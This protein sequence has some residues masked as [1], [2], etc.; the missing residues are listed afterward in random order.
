V[1]GAFASTETWALPPTA[2]DSGESWSVSVILSYSETVSAREMVTETVTAFVTRGDSY[3]IV[4]ESASLVR[5]VTFETAGATRLTAIVYQPIVIPV[6]RTT[7]VR[8]QLSLET[9]ETPYAGGTNN[10]LVIG[11]AT[12]AGLLVALIAGAVVFVLRSGRK[13]SGGSSSLEDDPKTKYIDVGLNEPVE[14]DAPLEES[15][16]PIDKDAFETRVNLADAAGDI[17]FGDQ[18]AASMTDEIWI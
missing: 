13:S 18:P 6:F 16:E 9:P 10:A 5:D 14:V 8:V 12:G 7:A 3:T 4:D 15:D 2:L 1:T 17:D 11:V